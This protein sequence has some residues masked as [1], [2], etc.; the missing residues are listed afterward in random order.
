M[1]GLAVVLLLVSACGSSGVG[2]IFGGGGGSNTQTNLVRGTVDYVDANNRTIV[3]RNVSGYNSMLSNS[4]SGST[5]RIYYDNQT[6]V[7][8]QGQ[9]Y[10]PTD[11]ERGD[12]VEV[13]VNESGSQLVAD[14]VTVTRNVAGTSGGSSSY[15]SY[16][17]T[18]RGTVRYIDTSRG[19]I[20][21]DRGN[22]TTT[23][24]EYPSSL[25]VTYNGSSYR[26]A[27]LERGD[28]I[29]IRVTDL[30][31]NRFRADAIT[32]VRSVS[33]NDN[34]TWNSGS[35]NAST[36]R[37]TVRYIDTARRTIE[38][39]ST[40]G[41]LGFNTNASTILVS[42]PSNTTVDVSGRA[43][44]ITGLE[45]GDVIEVQVDRSGSTYIANSI[46]LVRDVRQ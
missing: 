36:I 16:G 34:G 46:W 1:T 19:T 21:L 39:E 6:E 8:Y 14:V 2:D 35:S 27:D 22:G 3:L 37:G 23:F 15:P 40:T 38:L 29:E 42:Y 9:D 26:V 44:P 10:R 28:E 17:S 41:S 5:L 13:R 24:V 4:G 11:L 30:G 43:Q 25:N 33:S 45:R 12:E 32:V 20:E 18:L 31:S 7:Q